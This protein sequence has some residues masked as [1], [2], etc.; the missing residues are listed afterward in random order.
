MSRSPST[1][2]LINC[3]NSLEIDLTSSSPNHKLQFAV[4][5]VGETHAAMTSRREGG[6]CGLV[7]SPLCIVVKAG[8]VKIRVQALPFLSV[9]ARKNFHAVFRVHHSQPR[10]VCLSVTNRE[11]SLRPM[12]AELS[13]LPFDHQRHFRGVFQTQGGAAFLFDLSDDLHLIALVPRLN[14][15][16]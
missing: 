8:R 13:A 11:F 10:L 2:T 12:H 6:A 9:L 3:Y 16:R 14:T 4:T 1:W 15:Q 7:P 5:E